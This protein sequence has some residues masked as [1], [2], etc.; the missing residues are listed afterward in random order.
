MR[1]RRRRMRNGRRVD[2]GLGQEAESPGGVISD[3]NAGNTRGITDP[4]PSA[5]DGTF[6]PS[7]QDPSFDPGEA[8]K[9]AS[10][11]ALRPRAGGVS[12][13]RPQPQPDSTAIAELSE[14]TP[15]FLPLACFGLPGA[16]RK[17]GQHTSRSVLFSGARADRTSAEQQQAWYVASDGRDPAR[18]NRGRGILDGSSYYAILYLAR[19]TL[20]VRLYWPPWSRRKVEET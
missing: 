14:V 6:P 18:L 15:S 1:G 3:E 16:P 17:S 8:E 10:L 2:G 4:S 9:T 12:G 5:L 11:Q 20:F 19:V 13:G 7:T